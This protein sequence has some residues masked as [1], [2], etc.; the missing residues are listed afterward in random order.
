MER[1]EK[2]NDEA[3]LARQ[4]Q[5]GLDGNQN[6]YRQFLETVSKIIR[7]IVNARAGGLSLEDR[8][9]IVQDVIF[10][11]HSK[12]HTWRRDHPVKPWLN[13]IARYKIID[14][15]RQLGRGSFVDVD[16]YRENLPAEEADTTVHLDVETLVGMLSGKAQQVVQLIGLEGLTIAETAAR[17]DMK[18]N[19]VRVNFHRGLERL[20][21]LSNQAP[22]EGER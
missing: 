22:E 12:R 11:I 16:D 18:E 8:E 13:A 17:L 9:D 4:F 20:R 15:L 19:A 5:S 7:G 10:S 6:D 21:L 3:V 1:D 14:R 2:P